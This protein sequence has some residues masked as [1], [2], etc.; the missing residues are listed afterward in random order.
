[1]EV[2]GF[3]T[4]LY[5]INTLP[6]ELGI[7][8]LPWQNE[9]IAR[10][11]VNHPIYLDLLFTK[12]ISILTTTKTIHYIYRAILS[13]IIAPSMSPIH[14]LIWVCALAFQ[15]TNGLSIGG[16][17]GGHGP[18][19]SSSWH[20]A[21]FR[22]FLGLAVWTLGAAGNIYHDEVLRQIR[23]PSK[24]SQKNPDVKKVYK[25]PEG[26]LFKYV[27][28]P[29]YLFEWIEWLG[30]WIICGWTC[31]PARNFLIN[32]IAAM[33]P[34]AVSGKEWYIERFGREKVGGRKAI[35]PGVL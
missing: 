1:M 21:D 20:Q 13:P 34:R 8:D 27:L 22:I 29:H 11:F 6:T 7:I 3:L 24:S 33:L 9:A 30:F 35:L 26:G 18:I 14:P 23:R 25:I 2:P 32:E 4:V 19:E 5:I 31:V 16:F 12:S 15:V 28:Y 10:L 17:L